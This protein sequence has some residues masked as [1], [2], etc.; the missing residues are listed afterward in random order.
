[1][2]RSAASGGVGGG[3][4]GWVGGWLG[5]SYRHG[6]QIPRAQAIEIYSSCGLSGGVSENGEGGGPPRVLVSLFVLIIP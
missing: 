1:M 6:E 5:G 2:V 3:G 4:S